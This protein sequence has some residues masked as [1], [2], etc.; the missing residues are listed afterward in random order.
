MT[1]GPEHEAI[2]QWTVLWGMRAMS[3]TNLKCKNRDLQAYDLPGLRTVA[4][5]PEVTNANARVSCTI[6]MS[7][8]HL[9]DLFETV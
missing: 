2:R 5:C 3:S 4:S 1:A 9:S 7:T 8:S 6:P